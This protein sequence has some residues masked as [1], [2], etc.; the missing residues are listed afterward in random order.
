M[1]KI[2][3]TLLCSLA[4]GICSL[5]FAQGEYDIDKEIVSLRKELTDIASQRKSVK[6]EKRKDE[7]EFAEYIAR[8]KKRF[9]ALHAEIDSVQSAIKAQSA[10]NDSLLSAIDALQTAKRQVDL[11]Q[12]GFR[13]KCVAVCEGYLKMVQAFPPIVQKSFDASLSFLRS[14]LVA[15]NIESSEGVQRLSQIVKDIDEAAAS[16]QLVQGVSPVPE[17]RGTAYRI[18]LGMFY[19]AVVNM[20]GTAYAIWSGYTPDGKE[21]WRNGTDPAVAGQLFKWV[22]V[23]EGKALPEFV[24]LPLNEIQ[25]MEAGK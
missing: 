15:K 12:S 6:E 4:I 13:E 5:T 21:I 18:R 2:T 25:T 20:E 1:K 7:K 3:G 11:E 9:D 14:E 19:E 22:N 16:M 24:Q 17:I 8:N 10:V 23:R